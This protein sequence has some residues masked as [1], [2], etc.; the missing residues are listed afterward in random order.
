M[1]LALCFSGHPRTYTHCFDSIKK[2][3]LDKYDCDTFLSTYN[4]TENIND[5][6]IRLYKPKKY[7]FRNDSDVLKTVNKYNMD[8]LDNVKHFLTDPFDVGHINADD[9]KIYNIEEIYLHYEDKKFVYTKITNNTLCQ[10]FGFFDASK[11][12]LEYMTEHEINYDYILRLRLDDIFYNDFIPYQ[13]KENEILINMIHK[14]SDSINLHDMFFM[15]K[16]KTFFTIANLYNDLPNIIQFINSNKCWLPTSGYQE[17]LLYIHVLLCNIK[18]K[19][20][21]P[22]FACVKY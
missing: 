1:K 13:L 2:N 3:L 12:C 21:M 6:L 9:N 10:F 5:D 17:T 20:C 22:Q 14:Y 11:L 7:I 4:S 19:A 18:I 16:P 15:A 8:K